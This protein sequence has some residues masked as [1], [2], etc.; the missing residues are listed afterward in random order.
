[1][2]IILKM[3][4]NIYILFI[5]LISIISAEVKKRKLKNNIS[6]INLVFKGENKIGYFINSNFEYA[7]NEVLVNG[8]PNP[9]CSKNCYFGEGLYNITL[10]YEKEIESMFQM[11]LC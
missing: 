5:F 4:S 9:N 3:S 2:K 7:P 10:K 11:F 8:I 6:E 1:M